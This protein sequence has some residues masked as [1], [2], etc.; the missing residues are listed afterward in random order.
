MAHLHVRSLTKSF[1]PVRVLEDVSFTV[2]EGEFCILL[3]PS[4]CGKTTVQRIV[5]G[6]EDADGGQVW[7]GDREVSQLDPR[8]RDVAMVFQ[9][10]ALYPHMTVFENLAF[11]LRARKTPKE[12]I[13]GRVGDAAR[14]LGLEALLG[15]KPRELSGGQRQRVAIGRAIVRNPA[16]FLF[17]EPLSNLDA[18]L[19][20]AM[21]VELAG[22]HRSL[23]A[24]ILYVTH[25]QVEAMT[26]GQKV[27]LLHEGR[28]Q[29]TGTPRELYDRPANRFVAGFVGT[30]A[31]NFLEGRLRAEGQE[32]AFVGEGLR[33]ALGRREDLSPHRETAVTL[34]IR[35]EA[36]S[37]GSGEIEGRLELA[38]TLGAETLLHLRLSGGAAVV[39]KGPSDWSGPVGG[40]VRLEIR[41][42]GTH[43]FRDGERIGGGAGAGRPGD[44]G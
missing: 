30:P 38:E 29:Q 13:P 20:S 3:G 39:A 11:P 17:D 22:L 8:E 41:P 4:G 32:L 44:A 25:D 28:I 16:V 26:L 14:L 1:G 18:K 12:E 34:G 33:I 6:L 36:L 42:H 19:R 23:G 24:T 10:Y 21:R 9:S 2:E 7:I 5:A 35:P 31:M 37:P 40:P 15:R 43:L 27:V